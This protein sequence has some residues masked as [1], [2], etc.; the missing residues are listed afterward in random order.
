[1]KKKVGSFFKK[2]WKKLII[3][4]VGIVIVGFAVAVFLALYPFLNIE[5]VTTEGL[6]GLKLDG[7][8]KL[9]IVTHPDDELLWG[10]EHLLEDDYLVV[11]ITN[12]YNDTRRAEFEAVVAETGDKALILSYPDKIGSKRSSWNFW[13]EDIE[14]D[15]ETILSYKDWELVVTHNEDG[16]YGHQQHKMTSESVTK[17]YEELGCTAPLYYF[18]K[19]YKIEDVPYD[20]E[21][22]DKETYNRKREIA[23]IYK[24]QLSTVRKMYHMMPYEHWTLAK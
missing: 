6:D 24:S 13:R 15:L 21:E 16:E 23:K 1:M 22:M 2:H 18:G 7:Y 3:S 19:Y 11:C 5:P 14:Q 17:V 10:G 8:N 4:V 12:G 20:L 9:M